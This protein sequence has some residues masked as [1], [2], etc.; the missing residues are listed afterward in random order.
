MALEEVLARCIDKWRGED[1]PLRPPIGE[2]EIR[3]AWGRFGWPVSEDVLRLY[4]TVGGFADGHYDLGFFWCLWPWDRLQDENVSSPSGGIQ[5]CDHSI[6][7]VTWE[8][9]YEDGRRSSVWECSR[10]GP[11]WPRRTAEDLESFFRTYLDDPWELLWG[12]DR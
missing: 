1:I 6:D 12:G 5:F 7:L 8:V 3:R 11:D 10:A 4:T 9:R 2:T